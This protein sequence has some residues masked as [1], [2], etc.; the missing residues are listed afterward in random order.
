MAIVPSFAVAAYLPVTLIHSRSHQNRR[1][2]T[3]ML[4]VRNASATKF[5]EDLSAFKFPI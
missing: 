4:Q 1:L 5:L 2:R 3:T